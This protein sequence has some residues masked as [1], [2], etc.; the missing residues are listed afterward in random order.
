MSSTFANIGLD[1]PYSDR[2]LGAIT[3]R[4]QDAG[5]FKVPNLRN[6]ILT[7]PY[8]HDGR[9]QTL[10]QVLDHYSHGIKGDANLDTALKMPATG[11]PLRMN[12]TKHEKEAIIA[13]LGSLTDVDMITNPLYSVPFK[14]K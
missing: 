10:D 4:P 9:F 5:R 8:M 14:N 3:N 7:A 11:A 13:F 12:I 2:G 1:A 6:V